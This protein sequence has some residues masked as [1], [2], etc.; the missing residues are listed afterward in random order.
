MSTT[1]ETPPPPTLVYHRPS[2]RVTLTW[3]LAPPLVGACVV[4]VVLARHRNPSA[5][6]ATEAALPTEVVEQFWPNGQLHVRRQV[7]R[8]PDGRLV[9]HG[10]MTVWYEEGAQRSTG[11]WRHGRKHGHFV[12]WYPSG[13]KKMEATWREGLA[14][15]EFFAW[16]ETG[17]LTRREVWNFGQLVERH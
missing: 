13:S 10:E 11:N 14:N 15:G 9:N 4:A 16:D 5:T 2:W 1:A 6:P 12:F 17:E 7:E 3:L 8:T